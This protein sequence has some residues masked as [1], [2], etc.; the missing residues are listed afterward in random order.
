MRT[1]NVSAHKIP[2]GS[3]HGVWSGDTLAVHYDD[4]PVELTTD[5]PGPSGSHEVIVCVHANG[6]VDLF[7]P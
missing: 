5:E 6:T 1:V 3:Y 4:D 2:V 7:W